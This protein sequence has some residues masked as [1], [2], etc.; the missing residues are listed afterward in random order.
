MRDDLA[1]TSFPLRSRYM[2]RLLPLLGLSVLLLFGCK[3]KDKEEASDGGGGGDPGMMAGEGG[4]MEGEQGREGMMGGPGEGGMEGDPGMM[5]G[6]GG[7]M[8]GEQGRE[9]MM[10]DPGMME[11]GMQGEPGMAGDPGMMAGEGGMMQGGGITGPHVCRGPMGHL[12]VNIKRDG[13]IDAGLLKGKYRLGGN[14]SLTLSLFGKANMQGTMQRSPTG[15]RFAAQAGGIS[16]EFVRVAPFQNLQQLSGNWML[17]T[18]VMFGPGQKPAVEG[19]KKKACTISNGTISWGLTP[20]PAKSQ[21]FAAA[22]SGKGRFDRPAYGKT[23]AKRC[24]IYLGG[25]LMV[26]RHMKDESG[27]VR[28]FVFVK[29]AA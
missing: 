27:V 5:A 26:L 15:F 11:G 18:S 7:M 13:T 16:L 20:D 24:A 19:G 8:E 9:G 22:P 12:L 21:P 23:P 29:R 4:M 1:A 17:E 3:K 14:N 2:R 25:K 28:Y 10:G 6:E